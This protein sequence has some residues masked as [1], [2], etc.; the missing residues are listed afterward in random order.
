MKVKNRYA[1]GRRN[2]WKSMDK[3]RKAGWM[4]FRTA[5]SH[6]DWDIIALKKDWYPMLIQVKT[7][8]KSKVQ[9]SDDIDP[10]WILRLHVW[11]DYQGVTIYDAR[12]G[13]E[14]RRSGGQPVD[15]RKDD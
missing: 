8:H 10:N 1:K 15:G 6:S 12:N 7:N 2:E 3:L 5:G 14:I 4:C 11:I 9:I 13:L